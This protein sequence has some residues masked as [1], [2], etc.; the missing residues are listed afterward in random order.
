[1]DQRPMKRTRVK[2][3]EPSPFNFGLGGQVG[4]GFEA[5]VVREEDKETGDRGADSYDLNIRAAFEHSCS[6]RVAEN[7]EVINGNVVADGISAEDSRNFIE[8]EVEN[9]IA[10][11]LGIGVALNDHI[12]SSG[13]L[14]SKKVTM[15]FINGCYVVN[16]RGIGGDTKPGWIR[17]LKIKFGID[18]LVLQETKK[19]DVSVAELARY[20]GNNNFG[21]ESVNP[22]GHSGGLICL[23]NNSVFNQ[24]GVSKER[25]FLH[26]RGSLVG[27]DKAVKI[28]NI[29]APQGIPAKKD[30]WEDLAALISV[31]DG[32]WVVI[33]DFNA[34]RFPEEKRNC[35]FKRTC[36]NN[37]NSFIYDTGLLEY[38]I[39]GRP[40]TYC[41]DNG[42]K[43]SKLDRFL[44]NSEFFN[45][46][47]QAC[48]QVLPSMWSDHI[49][50]ILNMK[51][52]N[53]GARTFRIF[54]S[55]FGKEGFEEAVIEACN[56]FVY[57]GGPP[58]VQFIRKLGQIRN[59][60][61]SWRN[62]MIKKE[63]EVVSGAK[64]KLEEMEALLERRDL[65]E[66]EEWIFSENKKIVLEAE[67]LLAKDLKQRS[68][69]KWAK[70]GDENSKYFHSMINKRKACNAIRGLEV[71]DRWVSKPSLVKKEVFKFFR[72]NFVEECQ[73]RSSLNFSNLKKLSVTEAA[74]LEVLFSRNEIKTAVFEC[75]GDRAPGPYGMNFRFFKCFWGLFE[76]DFVGIMASFFES[77]SINRGVGRR[78]SPLFRKKEIRLV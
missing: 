56:S 68:R 77:G 64:E 7:H 59:K 9:T 21:M 8:K 14:F 66:E 55:W 20:W 6:S 1:M 12:I 67:L 35:A 37:F 41:S 24:T 31:N 2:R 54:N 25:N 32:L 65:T 38:P 62:V 51:A 34:V 61:K 52:V 19:G 78:L 17:S 72:S 26:I 69:V 74:G 75:G 36:A 15:G 47:P 60:L 71:E 18:F 45:L 30:L 11:G 10:F 29:Y 4:F 58:D 53:Y 76:E 48:F 50:I 13:T 39:N 23:W 16:I 3:D 22:S 43:M 40:F 49:P 28:L 70:D 5:S 73:S 27:V 42:K 57:H 46:W 63:G 44:I 33:G